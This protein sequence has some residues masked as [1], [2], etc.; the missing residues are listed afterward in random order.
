MNFEQ[1]IKEIEQELTALKTAAN[2]SST[3]SSSDIAVSVSTG[4]YQVVFEE[5][6]E[7]IMTQ[8]YLITDTPRLTAQPRTASMSVQVV[9][10]NTTYWD[11]ND[12]A[13]ETCSLEIVAN[14][15]IVSISRIS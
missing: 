7:A 12:Y 11:G 13:T 4:L 9:E 14:R 1:K 8:Y 6:D 2:Y 15:P 3:R 10:A 5:N